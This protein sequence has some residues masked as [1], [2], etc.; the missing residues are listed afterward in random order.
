MGESKGRTFSTSFVRDY[1]TGDNIGLNIQ[2]ICA[3]R[4]ARETFPSGEKWKFNKPIVL[5]IVGVIEACLFEIVA[6][7]RF[8]TRE[9]VPN[10]TQ[11]QLAGVQRSKKGGFDFLVQTCKQLKILG[12]IHSEIYPILLELA[13]LRDRIHIQ[14]EHRFQPRCERKAFTDERVF[15]AEKCLEIVLA[16][17]STNYG[18]PACYA[19]PVDLPWQHTEADINPSL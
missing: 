4:K 10:I 3:L 9:G 18:R 5:M 16:H 2:S 15:R 14:N 1:K 12:P 11:K 13:R 6:R 7:A 19:E 8:N 17:L